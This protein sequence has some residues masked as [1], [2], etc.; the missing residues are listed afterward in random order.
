MARMVLISTLITL[1]EWPRDAERR[2][3]AATVDRLEEYS[4]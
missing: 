1:R 3:F 4:A 2:R